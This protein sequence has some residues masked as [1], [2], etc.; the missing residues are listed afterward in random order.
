MGRGRF[1]A[2]EGE[3]S[4]DP[5]V[6]REQ[7]VALA[8]AIFAAAELAAGNITTETEFEVSQIRIMV[9]PNPGPTSYKVIITPTG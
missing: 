4:A 8:Q 2:F 6:E 3:A 1:D 5:N 9:S 7:G